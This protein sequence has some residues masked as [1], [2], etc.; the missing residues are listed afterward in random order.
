MFNA[1]I[2]TLLATGAVA[3]ITLSVNLPASTHEIHTHNIDIV[4]VVKLEPFGPGSTL[5]DFCGVCT[6][7]TDSQMNNYFLSGFSYPQASA[8][9]NKPVNLVK[10]GKLQLCTSE[11]RDCMT[12]DTVSN[13]GKSDLPEVFFSI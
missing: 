10:T 5:N 11:Q 8:L 9:I 3:L 13:H 7:V 2:I 6:M 1:K 12:I 4:N